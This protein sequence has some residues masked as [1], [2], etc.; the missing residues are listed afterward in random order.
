VFARYWNMRGVTSWHR[1]L[2]T[3]LLGLNNAILGL[4]MNIFW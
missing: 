1:V 3:N 4:T 2:K